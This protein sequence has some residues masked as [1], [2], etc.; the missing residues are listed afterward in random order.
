M[1]LTSSFPNKAARCGIFLALGCF[2]A[3]G[4]LAQSPSPVTNSNISQS[5]IEEIKSRFPELSEQEIQEALKRQ[6]LV[7]GEQVTLEN[8]PESVA[9][10]EEDDLLEEP[11]AEDE[12]EPELTDS[13][14]VV[15]SPEEV[16]EED[17]FAEEGEDGLGLEEDPLAEEGEDG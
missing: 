4:S 8:L 7:T 15:K 9:L 17:P 12:L 13:E 10:F 1:R 6:Q 16:L 5:L 3:F 14:E 11:T 2:L